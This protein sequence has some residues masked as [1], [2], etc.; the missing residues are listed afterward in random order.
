MGGI[1]VAG[2]VVADEEL[3]MMLVRPGGWMAFQ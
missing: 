1:V 2:P 3:A